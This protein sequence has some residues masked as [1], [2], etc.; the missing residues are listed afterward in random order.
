MAQIALAKIGKASKG[1]QLNGTPYIFKWKNNADDFKPRSALG[2]YLRIH[3]NGGRIRSCYSLNSINSPTLI[4]PLPQKIY[5][6]SYFSLKNCIQ[7]ADP[8]ACSV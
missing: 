2:D 1:C 6:K 4:I 5:S 8:V 3:K 7:L